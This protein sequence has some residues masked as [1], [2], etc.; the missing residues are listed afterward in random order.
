MSAN[1]LLRRL[2]ME[3][4]KT[5]VIGLDGA[6]LEL[7]LEDERLVNLRRLMEAGC[8]GPL[9]SV[10]PASSVPAWVCLATG[11]DPGLLGVYGFRN[12]ARSLLFRYEDRGQPVDDGGC[13]LERPRARPES[14]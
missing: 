12:R 1:P 4:L 5:L 9:Q 2:L 10:I 8:Y 7:L 3:S 11:L 6:T 13:R 14:P